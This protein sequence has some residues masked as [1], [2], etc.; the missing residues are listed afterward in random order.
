[1]RNHAASMLLWTVVASIAGLLGCLRCY[2][3][4]AYSKIK[5]VEVQILLEHSVQ[6]ARRGGHNL[7]NEFASSLAQ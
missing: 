7:V 3:E 4:R 2:E 5:E 6:V 1:M